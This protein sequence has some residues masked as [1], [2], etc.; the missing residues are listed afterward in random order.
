MHDVS[1][2]STAGARRGHGGDRGGGESAAGRSSSI[3][4]LW[5]KKAR[6]CTLLLNDKRVWVSRNRPQVS[7]ADFPADVYT[8]RERSGRRTDVGPRTRAFCLQRA[9]TD[10]LLDNDLHAAESAAQACPGTR[11]PAS[12]GIFEEKFYILQLKLRGTSL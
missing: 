2:R 4:C 9:K 6:G 1:D 7:K 5:E 3:Q 12:R 10:V 11:W 8:T